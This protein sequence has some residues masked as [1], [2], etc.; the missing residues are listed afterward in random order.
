MPLTHVPEKLYFAYQKKKDGLKERVNIHTFL[1]FNLFSPLFACT[2]KLLGN[3]ITTLV[4]LPSIHQIL[5]SWSVGIWLFM[6]SKVFYY[7][8]F[9]FIKTMA[10]TLCTALLHHYYI[11]YEYCYCHHCYTLC[12]YHNIFMELRYEAIYSTNIQH[13]GCCML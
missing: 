11:R 10:W 2:A 8:R 9:S 1:L 4:H 5:S 3:W 7:C 12:N 6:S 13:V